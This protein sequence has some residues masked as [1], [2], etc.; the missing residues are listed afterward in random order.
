MYKYNQFQKRDGSI[1]NKV[2]FN[3]EIVTEENE[4]HFR[5]LENLKK[6]QSSDKF[7]QYSSAVPFPALEPLS[8]TE[9]YSLLKDLWT[10]KAF[11]IDCISDCI[12]KR[13]IRMMWYEC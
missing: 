10:G 2:F 8:E 3:G 9:M 5:I 6:I 13:N 1:A 7:P 12:S 11:S 4:V